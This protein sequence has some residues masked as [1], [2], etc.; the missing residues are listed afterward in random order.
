MS[1]NLAFSKFKSQEFNAIS[2]LLCNIFD[3][4]KSEL[5]LLY[6]E[7]IDDFRKDGWPPHFVSRDFFKS[8]D[9]EFQKIYKISP[10]IAVDLPSLFELDDGISNKP[11]IVILGQDSKSDQNSE[12]IS[13]GTPYGLHHKGSREVLRRTKLYFEMITTLLG[14]GHRV[15]LTDIY[16]VW[17]CD[18]KR[19]YYGV[20]LPRVDQ[21]KFVSALKLE[22]LAMNPV[23]LV[24]WGK[25]S[26]NSVAEINLSIQ[27]LNF[28]HPSGTANGTW[29][30]LMDQSPTYE[31]KLA[32]W[33]FEV[34]K[35][36]P[37]KV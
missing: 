4:K 9:E 22:I 23:A 20:K 2:E 18:P 33:N 29:K 25:E 16:K 37:R 31:N 21:D 11:T 10:V 24:T 30:K 6:Q 19:P 13:L 17:V 35:L 36:L 14:L 27:H 5:E 12:K 28:P 32:Y 26:A 3:T 1:D 7:I 15:Y 8:E 34:S